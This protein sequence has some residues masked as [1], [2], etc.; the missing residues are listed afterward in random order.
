M[1]AAEQALEA[2]GAA[3][4]RYTS[5]T[6]DG[7]AEDTV[8]VL[9]RVFGWLLVVGGL[10]HALGSWMAY[11][12]APPE[13]LWAL[14]GSLAALLLAALNLLRAGRPQDRPLAWVS[15]GGC[16]AWMVVSVSFGRVIGNVLDRRAVIHALN[17]AA[18]AV[19]SWR[20]L[21][22]ASRQVVA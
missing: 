20:T 17:A 6:L 7:N 11:R 14:S 1:S 12:N 21:V 13:L 5:I 19:M 2:G 15:L 9:D 8:N 22:R 3:L 4:L 16:L 18:L 10:L